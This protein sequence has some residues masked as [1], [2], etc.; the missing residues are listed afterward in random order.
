MQRADSYGT[1]RLSKVQKHYGPIVA[2]SDV[3]LEVESGE[4]CVFVG[5]SGCGKSTLLRM[6]AGLEDITAGEIE[7]GGRMVNGIEPGDRGVAMVFQN[8]ALYPHKTVFENMAFALRNERRPSHEIN[9]RVRDAAEMLQIEPLLQRKPKALSGGQRQRVAI[10]RAIVRHPEVFLFDEPLSNLDAALRGQ[11]RTE[12]AAL[13]RRL[14][15]TII[16]VTHDQT[17]AMTLGDR[18]VVLRAG[19]VE[20][21]GAPL[22]LYNTPINTF[23][24]TFIGSPPMNLISVEATPTGNGAVLLRLPGG[25]ELISTCPREAPLPTVLGVRPEHLALDH[26][27]GPGA[28]K[29]EVELVEH[30]GI[31]TVISVR[32]DAGPLRLQ[33]A[34]QNPVRLG[35][36][37]AIVTAGPLHLFDENGQRCCA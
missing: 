31:A 17:E 36:R 2:V 5:P 26:S 15:V 13:H 20:Q 19:R 32:T 27:G 37:V 34:G 24:A 10:G 1:I 18:I 4:F 22:D 35:D 23:V 8:Y 25:T 28:I 21:I 33:I 14:G 3:D 11:T 29:A 6:I 16:F 30:L 7:I 12:L 9:Q